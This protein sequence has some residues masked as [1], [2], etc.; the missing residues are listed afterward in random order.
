VH[1]QEICD[2][3]GDKIKDGYF[4]PLFFLRFSFLSFFLS[5]IED[6]LITISSDNKKVDRIATQF[7]SI[8]NLINLPMV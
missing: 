4:L 7:D 8:R 1:G 2:V 6:I 5:V 3:R